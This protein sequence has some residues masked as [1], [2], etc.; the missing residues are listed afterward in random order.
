MTDESEI[1]NMLDDV[2]YG[3]LNANLGEIVIL[4]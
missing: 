2:N 1:R 3:V 4:K